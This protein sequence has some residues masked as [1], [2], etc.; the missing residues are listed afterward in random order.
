MQQIASIVDL[1]G[2]ILPPFGVVYLLDHGSVAE[3]EIQ[4][5]I[6]A[7]ISAPSSR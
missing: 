6:L 3:G 4:N 7:R 5:R 1:S 2:F